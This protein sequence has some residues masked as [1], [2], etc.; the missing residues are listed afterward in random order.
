MDV[1]PVEPLR[2]VPGLLIGGRLEA[3]ERAEAIRVLGCEIE[4]EAPANRATHDHRA[5]QLKGVAD[6]E[7]H[8]RVARGGKLVLL[9]FEARGR[10]R[11]SMPGHV[12]DDDAVVARDRGVIEHVA[13]LAAVGAGRVQ[14]DERD[15][16]AGLLDVEAMR[17]ARERQVRIAADDRLESGFCWGLH[18]RLLTSVRGAQ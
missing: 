1:R 16:A 2:V 14:A 5:I 13:E 11:L 7:H 17:T 9:G 12:E 6:I 18:A 8:L 10:Q 3:D 15:A 4:H